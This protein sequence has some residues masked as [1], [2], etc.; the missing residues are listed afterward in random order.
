MADFCQ[1]TRDAFG[2]LIQKPPLT[3]E[4]LQRPPFRFLHDVI[5]ATINAS[6]FL[7]GLYTADEMDPAKVKD[8]DAKCA[9]LQKAIDSVNSATGSKLD[10]KPAKIVAGKDADKTNEFLQALAFAARNNSGNSVDAISAKGTT[11][12]NLAS[13]SGSAGS[14]KENR[15]TANGHDADS[16]KKSKEK[17]HKSRDKEKDKD[18]DKDKDKEKKHKEKDPDKKKKEKSADDGKE[19]KERSKDKE[20][21]SKDKEKDKEKE[22]KH[23]DKDDDKS[24]ERS[25]S[26]DKKHRSDSKSKEKSSKKEK[27]SADVQQF[28]I[29]N[30]SADDPESVERRE[31]IDDERTTVVART[32]GRP[33]TSMGRPMTSMG[34]PGTA[35]ARPAPPKLKRKELGE[36]EKKPMTELAAGETSNIITTS[37]VI[38]SDA[39]DDTDNFLVE[40]PVGPS[41]GDAFADQVDAEDLDANEHGGLV[42]KIL[43]TKKEL[44][45]GL[46]D[47]GKDSKLTTVVFDEKER[48]KTRKEAQKI[49]DFIQKLTRSS[50]PLGRLLD[51]LQV[52][53]TLINLCIVICTEFFPMSAS[54]TLIRG[55]SPNKHP[56]APTRI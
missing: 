42:R 14:N 22:K 11:D 23:R 37:A 21:R 8:K 4:L 32:A 34:R 49:Q 39:K 10:V 6:G 40:E 12:N 52:H 7:D 35:M 19:K 13:S 29:M 31:S 15:V 56:G 51:Y 3:D 54:G 24:K 18:K 28:D 20:H 38:S 26:K 1:T 46:D 16:D 43:E 50:H 5:T 36:V 30:I 45:S 2:D 53:P 48:E 9:F 27:P 17:R 44:E 41:V 33:T 25:S 47:A 55:D